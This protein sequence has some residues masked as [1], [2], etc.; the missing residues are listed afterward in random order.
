MSQGNLKATLM[1]QN[2]GVIKKSPTVYYNKNKYLGSMFHFIEIPNYVRCNHHS[3][4]GNIIKQML[5]SINF[6]APTVLILSAS[7][8]SFLFR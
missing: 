8:D 4:Y 3:I 7:F 6:I 2:L 1:Y 5:K